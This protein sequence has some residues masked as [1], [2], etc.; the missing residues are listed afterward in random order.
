MELCGENLRPWLND[1][2]TTNKND[3]I[4]ELR[5]V[6][7]Y[8]VQ[9]IKNAIAGLDFLHANEIIHRD[10][11]PENIMFSRPGYQLPVK[12][13]DFGLNANRESNK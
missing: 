9:I 2:T 13:G 11:K 5:K 12:I 10:L 1:L 3:N 6:Q 8:Q 4:F 7:L